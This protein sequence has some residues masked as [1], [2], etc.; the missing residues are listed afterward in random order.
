MF[1]TD[2]TWCNVVSSLLYRFCITYAVAML[3]CLLRFR[4]PWLTMS[5]ADVESAYTLT[6]YWIDNWVCCVVR[7]YVVSFADFEYVWGLIDF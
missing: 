6:V 2:S 1:L 4:I 7:S 3:K 5:I